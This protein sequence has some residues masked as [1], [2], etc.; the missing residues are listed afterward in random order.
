[1]EKNPI[2]AG[3]SLIGGVIYALTCGL[4]LK[5]LLASGVAS[6]SATASLNG[7]EVGSQ[8]MIA[9]LL[10]QVQIQPVELTTGE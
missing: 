8:K 7:T 3:D 5:E 2:G 9:E 6:G 10:L 4:S 1:M